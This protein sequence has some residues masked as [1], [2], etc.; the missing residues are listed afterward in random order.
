MIFLRDEETADR[1]VTEEAGI[2]DAFALIEAVRF[3]GA[4]FCPLVGP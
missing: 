2:R 4:Y 1:W 3:A